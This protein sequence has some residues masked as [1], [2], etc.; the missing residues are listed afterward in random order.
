SKLTVINNNTAN[1]LY[2][3]LDTGEYPYSILTKNKVLYLLINGQEFGGITLSQ[4]ELTLNQNELSTGS[5]ADGFVV[6][7]EK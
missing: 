7:L 3:G 6:L 4:N 1:T 2:D 5:G